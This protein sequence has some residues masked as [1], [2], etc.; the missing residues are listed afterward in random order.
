M[1]KNCTTVYYLANLMLFFKNI[2]LTQ[3]RNYVFQSFDFNKKIIGICGQNGSGKT[4]LLDAIHYLCFTKTYFS[5]TD[6]QS[7]YQGL[8]GFRIEGGV[9]KNK[10]EHKLICILRENNRKEFLQNGEIY[11]RFSEHIGQFPCVMIAPDDIELINGAS[12]E[13]RKF[14]DTILSQLYTQYLQNLIDYNKLLQQRNSVLKTAAEYNR[15]DESLLEIL[16]EQIAEKA[17]LI[18]NWRNNF[19][20]QFLPLVKEQ[21][22]AI[23][24]KN[25]SI[26]ILYDSQLKNISMKDLLKENR[27]R[28]LYLQRTTCGIHKDDLE[29]VMNNQPAKSLASQG[30]K[31]SLLFALKLAEFNALKKH[32]G[33]APVLLLDDAFEKLDAQR[34]QNLL[35][36]V[37]NQQ[38]Q[39]FIT[40]THKNR[41]QAA[42]EQLQS[43]FQMIELS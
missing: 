5:K 38:A 30:Q 41:L 10:E 28:D 15:L 12:E 1:Q 40:D 11:K 26:E 22:V 17:Q 21:Y 43:D 29:I 42:F 36:E 39:I 24:E 16:N 23:S 4:N 7:V 33:F 35:S 20:Q 6:L 2:T 32:A 18:Y 9:I 8:Q 37:C 31:K 13:R 27:E 14:I 25:D 34:M 19:L 3:F